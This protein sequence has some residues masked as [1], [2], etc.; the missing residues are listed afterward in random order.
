M[1][2][3]SNH[4]F[5]GVLGVAETALGPPDTLS[6]TNLVSQFLDS[7]KAA[8]TMTSLFKKKKKG[9]VTVHRRISAQLHCSTCVLPGTTCA[10]A[11]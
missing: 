6:K 8:K 3:G 4:L 2:Y 7:S 11:H 1:G 5:C 10:H 9:D